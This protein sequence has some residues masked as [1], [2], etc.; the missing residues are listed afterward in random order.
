[1][2]NR[3]STP[4]TRTFNLQ[5]FDRNGSPVLRNKTQAEYDSPASCPRNF[6]LMQAPAKDLNCEDAR[7]AQDIYKNV[8]I[9]P[10]NVGD[11]EPAAQQARVSGFSTHIGT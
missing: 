8:H 2:D 7:K 3:I 4:P 10:F 6:R 9:T 5:A 1:M 11:A